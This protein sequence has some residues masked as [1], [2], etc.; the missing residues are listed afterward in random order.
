MKPP[1]G[2]YR[3]ASGAEQEM[4]ATFDSMMEMMTSKIIE[5]FPES[6]PGIII[7]A[8][9]ILS[10]LDSGGS[11]ST[12][13]YASILVSLLTSGFVSATVSYDKDTDPNGRAFNPDFY[14]YVPD[15]AR[16]RCSSLR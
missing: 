7:Q 6:V 11:V 12:T 13:A 3:V 16:K 8:S 9:W 1:V 2:A 10:E 14:G 15:D 5:M 4:D